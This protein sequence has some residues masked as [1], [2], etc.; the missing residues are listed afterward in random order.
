MKFGT[1][2]SAVVRGRRRYLK[3]KEPSYTIDL[4]MDS[5]DLREVQFSIV[6]HHVAPF[7]QKEEMS[8]VELAKLIRDAHII[9]SK[10]RYSDVAY[11]FMVS[12]VDTIFQGRPMHRMGTHAGRSLEAD[13]YKGSKIEA[14]KFD[15]DYLMIGVALMGD[16][17]RQG[18][19]SESHQKT[20]REFIRYL[21]REYNIPKDRIYSHCQ[22]LEVI[23]EKDLTLTKPKSCRECPGEHTP[24]I[25]CLL[26]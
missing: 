23:K 12:A 20:S 7:Y 17:T 8:A 4:G 11:H 5:C 26:E 25:E 15:P 3:V 24:S 14:Q 19:M 1:Y 16:F 6:I 21:M 2:F 18:P 10:R 13:K 22:M 9:D